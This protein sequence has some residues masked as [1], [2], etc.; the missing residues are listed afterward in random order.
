MLG[1]KYNS[2]LEVT[3]KENQITLPSSLIENVDVKNF[4]V[5]SNLV[6]K[7]KTKVNKKNA[8]SNFETN[9]VDEKVNF[10]QCKLCNN[11]IVKSIIKKQKVL[12]S[13]YWEELLE[14]Y[15]C[16]NEE[17]NGF[18][19]RT[20]VPDPHTIFIGL[21][22]YLIHVSK[23]DNLTKDVRC[24][25]CNTVLGEVAETKTDKASGSSALKIFKDKVFSYELLPKPGIS[26]FVLKRNK[27]LHFTSF[28]LKSLLEI[29]FNQATYKFLLYKENENHPRLF[30][31]ML[32]NEIELFS[33]LRPLK[34]EIHNNFKELNVIKDVFGKIDYDN[35]TKGNMDIIYLILY[36]LK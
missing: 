19:T 16:H 29:G 9:F 33:N 8:L 18:L 1:L 7:F 12:P 10:L 36:P 6:I 26:E 23:T 5:T 11:K 35:L 17:H 13:T 22:F 4:T 32:N 28:F 25:R 14:C 21:H 31:W 15:F 27:S 3:T 30:L 20:F 24:N 34:K 2:Y